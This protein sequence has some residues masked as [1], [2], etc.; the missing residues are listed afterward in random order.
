MSV[1]LKF[2]HVL[3]NR[4]MLTS[5]LTFA[6]F[7]PKT[8]LFSSSCCT[9]LN[10]TK[11]TPCRQNCEIPRQRV[12]YLGASVVRFYEEALYQV[13]LLFVTFLYSC[14]V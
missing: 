3:A 5:A 1:D 12:P 8:R 9:E 14:E 6:V 2:M 11:R 4:Y 7:R 13:S 10:L